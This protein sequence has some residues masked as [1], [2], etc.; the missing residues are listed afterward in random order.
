VLAR[1]FARFAVFLV[2]FAVLMAL[3]YLLGLT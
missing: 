3:A 2:V 1:L